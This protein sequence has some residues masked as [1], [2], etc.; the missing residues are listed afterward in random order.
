MGS[1]TIQLDD[2]I[3]RAL[4]READEE[5][6]SLSEYVHQLVEKGREYD[7]VERKLEHELDRRAELQLQL[8]KLSDSKTQSG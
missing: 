8:K 4:E 2:E 5:G 1:L 7:E 6:M 3:Q